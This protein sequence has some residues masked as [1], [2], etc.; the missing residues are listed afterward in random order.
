MSMETTLQ[1]S[2]Y[3]Y[4]EA[5]IK[6]HLEILRTV[7]VF[8]FGAG[9][10]GCSLVQLLHIYDVR[11]IAF[12]DNSTEKQG[13]VIEGCRV[14]AFE[15]ANAYQGKNLF[16]CPV[17]K[18]ESILEQLASTGRRE[19]V[20]Y[21]NLDFLFTDY[22]DL[23]E[24]IKKPVENYAWIFGS[25]EL[26]SYVLCEKVGIS[27]GELLRE[28]CLGVDCKVGSLP[29]F[30]STIYYHMFNALPEVDKPRFV[31]INM[32]L[33]SA[34]PY[35]PMMLGTQNYE[36]HRQFLKELKKLSPRKDE[37][38]RYQQVVEERWERSKREHIMPTQYSEEATRKVY[39]LKYLYKAREEDES[40]VSMKKL[41]SCLNERKIP[42][43]VVLPPVDY[44]R[45]EKL[46][47]DG[48]KRLYME[49]REQYLS[50]LKGYT[51]AK[52]D[53]SFIATSEYFVPPTNKPDINPFLNL[54][55]QALFWKYLKENE[56]IQEILGPYIGD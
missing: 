13:K 35:A 42:V 8:I 9:V 37:I 31:F 11:D 21:Y 30:Y 26:S 7:R 28:K 29:G 20:D 54:K 12:V 53:A 16:L 23:I 50:F 39:R 40:V 2:Y 33:S 14:L 38:S 4:L 18:G 3:C 24:E 44:E 25:C 22:A 6:E 51:F 10:R 46:F 17:E 43:I 56:R 55:G 15:Q 45:G 19:N 1:K 52:I 27:L 41:L 48:F 34:S 32:E 36:Q 49:T 47:G 5:F